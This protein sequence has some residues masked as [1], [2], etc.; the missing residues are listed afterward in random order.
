MFAPRVA[1]ADRM[2]T[3]QVAL[4]PIGTKGLSGCGPVFCW[5]GCCVSIPSFPSFSMGGAAEA[6]CRGAGPPGPLGGWMM[7]PVPPWRLIYCILDHCAND[8]FIFFC[9]FI[10]HGCAARVW[11]HIQ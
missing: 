1:R 11:G 7:H 8:F 2:S 10:V 9:W 4:G 6:S 3:P 5:F